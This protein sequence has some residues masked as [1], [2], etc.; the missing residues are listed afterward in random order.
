MREKERERERERLTQHVVLWV[1]DNVYEGGEQQEKYEESL[2]EKKENEM[3]SLVET[4]GKSGEE[5]EIA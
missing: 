1:C 5:R 4:M 2:R 3:T